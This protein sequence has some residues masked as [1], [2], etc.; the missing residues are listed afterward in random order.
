MRWIIASHL[1]TAVG[2]QQFREAWRKLHT[3]IGFERYYSFFHY[4]L[5]FCRYVMLQKIVR[6]NRNGGAKAVLGGGTAPLAPPPPPE[7]WH[8]LVVLKRLTDHT[9]GNLWIP[10]VKTFFFWSSPHIPQI[11]LR[12]VLVFYGCPIF[13]PQKYGK[14]TF[15]H[16][17]VNLM[18]ESFLFAIFV[19]V[20]NFQ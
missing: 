17:S 16:Q 4:C 7:R 8:C 5:L 15:K 20:L 12:K 18:I 3:K 10:E 9:R 19:C 11:I 2:W 6:V 13:L 14:P 1:C